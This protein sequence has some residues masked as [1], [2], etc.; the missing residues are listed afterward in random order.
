MVNL[1]NKKICLLLI[2]PPK[3]RTNVYFDKTLQNRFHQENTKKTFWQN[4]QKVWFFVS[5]CFFLSYLKMK[6]VKMVCVT[7]K[8]KLKPHYQT[9]QSKD[10]IF[11]LGVKANSPQLSL[12]YSCLC[13]EKKK[14]SG[15]NWGGEIFGQWETNMPKSKQG[16][17]ICHQ[18]KHFL[19]WPS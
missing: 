14:T 5:P 15:K 11:L 16:E 2:N 10:I 1:D 8:K 4:L 17:V 7:Q 19:M 18:G 12:G 9:L 13:L 3:G 6:L